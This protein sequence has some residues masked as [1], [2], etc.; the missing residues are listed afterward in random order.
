MSLKP[1]EM[2]SAVMK[3]LSKLIANRSGGTRTMVPILAAP[4]VFVF[5]KLKPSRRKSTSP[6]PT[7][8][9][10]GT[11]ANMANTLE[12]CMITVD[13]APRLRRY[14][15][16]LSLCKSFHESEGPLQRNAYQDNIQPERVHD[17]GDERPDDDGDPEGRF[18]VV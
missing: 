8:K 9:K 11:S 13:W 1:L 12:G 14:D 3:I 17:E 6:M 18:M 7:P 16:G 5:P 4:R 15:A 10:E 2:S